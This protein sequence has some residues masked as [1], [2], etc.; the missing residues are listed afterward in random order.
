[1][2][3]SLVKKKLFLFVWG[4]FVQD[5]AQSPSLKGTRKREIVF[6]AGPEPGSV[7]VPAPSDKD[8]ASDPSLEDVLLFFSSY[9]LPAP[10]SHLGTAHF[11]VP[12]NNKML[13][14]LMLGSAQLSHKTGATTELELAMVFTF[15]KQKER[16]GWKN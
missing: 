12:C 13:F 10:F 5:Y 4:S 7:S 15:L 6:R 11:S 1:M 14:V 16:A 3:E 8:S 2:W 9:V